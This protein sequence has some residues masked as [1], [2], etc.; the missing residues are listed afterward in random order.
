VIVK[1]LPRQLSLR[2]LEKKT[3]AQWQVDHTYEKV[4]QQKKD[5]PVFNFIDG[6]P[7][8]TGSI[9]LGTAWN[10]I[11]KDIVLRYKRMR[12]FNVIDTPGYDM[13]GLP[14]EVK[15]E[16]ELNIKSKKEIEQN[17]EEFVEKC[18]HFALINLDTMSEQFSELGVWMDWKKPYMTLSD[19]YIEGIW[20]TMKKAYD[21]GYVYRGVKVL[22][23]CP[24]CETALA[25]HEHE[26][27]TVE[28]VSIFVKLRVKGKPNEF[29]VVW[30]TTPW[31]LP[32]NLA[33]LAH[34]DYEYVRVKVG[35]E[36]WVM[37]KA[38]ATV[39]IQGLLE[40]DFQVVEEVK[41][42][43]LEGLKY[44]HPLVEEV[45]IQAQLDKK[46]KKAHT[47]V[48]S[49]E[50]VTLEQGTGLVH[51]APGHGPEDFEVGKQNGLPPFSP[52]DYAK[53]TSEAGKYAGIF[54]KKADEAIIKDLERKGLLIYK[55]TIKHEYAHC[56]RCHSPLLFQATN[57]W[58]IKV[59]DLKEA[60]QKENT[61][62][63]WVPDWAGRQS[64]KN[65]IDGLQDWCISRQRYW[66][67]PLPIWVCDSCG[68]VE[69][70]GSKKELI[71]KAGKTPK[72]LHKPWVDELT[73][74]CEKC[75]RKGTK[76][77]IP[78]VLDVWLDSGS[79]I[80]ATL[81]VTTGSTDYD[82]WQE[83]D[84][85]I[86][87]KEQIRGWFNS[88]MCSSMVAY[89]RWPYKSVYMHG[90]MCDEQGREMH[91]S[92]GNYIEP[93]E[94]ISK[95][96]VESYRFY[97]SKSGLPGDDI[98]FNWKDMA[99]T[100]RSLNIAWNVYVFASTF[101]AD[102][103]YDPSKFK[104]DG[105]KLQPE[106]RWI[107]S[108][109]NTV[110][111]E[112]TEAMENYVIPTAPRALQDFVVK[113]L[114]RWYIKLIRARTWV[115]TSGPN[116][117]AALTTLFN[118]LEKLAYLL[119]P[120]TPML[121]EAFYQS[122]IRPTSEDSLES[123]HMCQWPEVTEKCIDIELE[124]KMDYAREIV[125]TTL[126]I[127]QEAKVKLRWPCRKLIIVPKE[128]SLDIADLLDVIKDQASVK[129]IQ[130][131]SQLKQEDKT[132][133]LKEKETSQ[134]T[135]YLDMSTTEELESERLTKD[136]IR[137]IQSL[138]KKYGY[139]VSEKIELI[140]ATSNRQIT[141]GLETQEEQIR[142]KIGA[143]KID[144]LGKMPEELT[145]YDAQDEFEYQGTKIHVA[146]RKKT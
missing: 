15:V 57:Q 143:V 88:L 115:T 95:H 122:L 25:R 22:E 94:V 103:K 30:T 45:P 72:E 19:S 123:I 7:Y 6:P 59:A 2:E 105:M 82:S 134:S 87:G 58:F 65:W 111:K 139:H 89:G 118:V 76:R 102:A 97:S 142:N 3:L 51:C 104:L 119:A 36:V 100:D 70:L 23:V 39:L 49:S 107:L 62:T 47:I 60:M 35:N 92:L 16:Q 120:L 24:R 131:L 140:V 9:H 146:F 130:V 110:A 85:I 32:A 113:D 129:E 81:P 34:P 5:K 98:R 63:H 21:R 74:K 41:G 40:K 55:G 73:W 136:F 96:G 53:F 99:D 43:D 79:C 138:R 10:K 17:V 44:E 71:G 48:L 114:S 61:K 144:K 84:F 125:E 67:A 108:R 14:I 50:Y 86:E 29:L 46:Y 20:R 13:H 42:R 93:K 69:V 18:R 101:M 56:W 54:P 117:T 52:I 26:Y 66:G 124:S 1:E 38:L 106:D 68:D 31:T 75:H 141:E 8:T 133:N 135:L 109:I 27:K 28:D 116:K 11:M 128:K 121:S 78:D 132:E 83:R 91:K 80:W 127:R 145:G 4:K 112:V 90:F 12:G 126:A 64:F 137:R 37:A 77:R 33:V